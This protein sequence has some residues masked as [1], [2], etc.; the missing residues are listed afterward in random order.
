MLSVYSPNRQL[1][2]R[3]SQNS[4]FLGSPP[5]FFLRRSFHGVTE[6]AVTGVGEGGL[7]GLNRRLVPDTS[8]A[9]ALSAELSIMLCIPI[10]HTGSDQ[11][12]NSP[13]TPSTPGSFPA[14]PGLFDYRSGRAS[15]RVCAVVCVNGAADS[16]TAGLPLGFP[17][18][19]LGPRS[20]RSGSSTTSRGA[21]ARD[22]TPSE[23]AVLSCFY[24]NRMQM[25]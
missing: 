14:P 13:L 8:A 24:A 23:S 12:P 20:G 17:S 10:R 22:H 15:A 11:P 6:G 5:P 21:G 25:M 3:I 16:R 4:A 7:L 1:P 19:S 2:G 9:P 18:P